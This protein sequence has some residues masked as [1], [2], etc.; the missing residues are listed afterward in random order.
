VG[1]RRRRVGERRRL[2]PVLPA[3]SAYHHNV[4]NSN[5][6]DDKVYSIQH[7]VIMLF[8]KLR[9]VDG[10][11]WVFRFSIPLS[12]CPSIISIKEGRTGYGYYLQFI[13]TGEYILCKN[14]RIDFNTVTL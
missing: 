1:K 6:A 2:P 9:K 13:D 8:S 5:P 11:L 4:V 12:I 10:F 14:K 7:Y 3:I